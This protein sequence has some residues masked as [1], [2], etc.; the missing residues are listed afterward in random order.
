MMPRGPHATAH[1][2]IAVSKVVNASRHA[3]ARRLEGGAD[4]RRAHAHHLA[5]RRRQLVRQHVGDPHEAAGVLA[6][7]DDLRRRVVVGRPQWA[8]DHRVDEAA[9][10][11]VD[12]DEHLPG[13]RTVDEGDDPGVAVGL[14]GDDEAA[15]EPLV[16][17]AEVAQRGP[18]GV[19]RGGDGELL[20]D[21]CHGGP[22]S[23]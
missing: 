23:Q 1:V 13:N 4:R 5:D 21:G 14:G 10:V 9:G 19:G 20:T 2:P 6:V 16:H 8:L 3:D 18:D 7:R 17:G 12:G 15:G 22:P 11:V